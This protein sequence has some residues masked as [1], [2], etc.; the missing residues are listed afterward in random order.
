MK[1]EKILIP[2]DFSETSLLA[3]E[4]AAYVAR[5]FQA[6][7][8]LLH[9]VEKHWEKFNIVVPEMRIA[10]PD[11]IITII[12]K[13]LEELAKSIFLDYGVK[14][15]CITANGTIFSEILSISKEQEIDL[16][17]MGTHGTSG[18]VEFFLGS[19]AYKVVN[20]SDCPVLTVN[21][22]A[23][24]IGFDSI[25]LPIDNSA[26]SRHKVNKA[27]AIARQFS[28]II[29]VLGLA[30]FTDEK[31]LGIFEIK[32]EQVEDYIRKCNIVCNKQII[33]GNNQATMTLDYAQQI[34][35]D[36]IVI[37]TDQDENISGRLLGTYAQ[38]IVNHSKIPVMSV[39]PIP[40]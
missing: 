37:M 32:I 35:T 24:K 39:Q 40:S 7:L 17:V 33:R 10:A 19:N 14:S 21:T 27:I 3:V 38:Q 13:R 22:H 26:H 29:H 34:N 12:E 30:D 20:S 15:Y 6:E 4:H 18:F 8:V 11:D 28:S 9:V 2:T 25:V 36:L 16:I 5:T 31:E 23:T 1:I